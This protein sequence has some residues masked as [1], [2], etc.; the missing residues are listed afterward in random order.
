MVAHQVRPFLQTES[1]LLLSPIQDCCP[2][3]ITPGVFSNIA[4]K[5]THCRQFIAE[6]V[7][8]GEERS[9]N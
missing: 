3:T 5:D 1:S 7:P 8:R 9:I 4:A 2:P 6:K